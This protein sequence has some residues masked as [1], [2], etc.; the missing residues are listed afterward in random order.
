MQQVPCTNTSR[1]QTDGSSGHCPRSCDLTH[2]RE[3]DAHERGNAVRCTVLPGSASAHAPDM[4]GHR[5][6]QADRI[7]LSRCHSIMQ[8]VKEAM[9]GMAAHDTLQHVCCHDALEWS[10]DPPHPRVWMVRNEVHA[11]RSQKMPCIAAHHNDRAQVPQGIGVWPGTAE[12]VPLDGAWPA[13]RACRG[14]TP[15]WQAPAC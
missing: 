13:I 5:C 3:W 15:W 2:S 10:L 6:P 12:E 1:A 8:G 11:M 14:F 9:H 4:P 7:C